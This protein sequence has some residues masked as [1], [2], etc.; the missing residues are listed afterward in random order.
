MRV[1]AIAQP[2]RHPSG[3]DEGLGKR[4]PVFLCSI[5]SRDCGIICRCQGKGLARQRSPRRRT[6]RRRQRG[7]FREHTV[8]IGRVGHHCHGFM[9]LGGG[10]DERHAAD[11]DVLDAILRAR[12]GGN[13]FGK[14]IEVTDEEIDRGD[15]PFG[16]RCEVIPPVTACQQAGMDRRVQGSSPARREF[17]E[18]R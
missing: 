14:G 1:L 17:R 6:D 12:P 8:V 5:H 3:K 18:S 16:Q 2:L 4:D 15:A 9:V 13:G 10:P 7:E 11:I